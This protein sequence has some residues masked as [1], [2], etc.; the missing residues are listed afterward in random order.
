MAKLTISELRTELAKRLKQVIS[1]TDT[2]TLD[3]AIQRAVR[4]IDSLASYTFL[5]KKATGTLFAYT[6]YINV[7]NDLNINKEIKLYL[8]DILM[9]FVPYTELNKYTS[10]FTNYPVAYAYV[11]DA[12]TPKFEFNS[13]AGMNL[14]YKL[15][16][17]KIMTMPAVGVYAEIPEQWYDIIIDVAEYQQ[18]MLY[19]IIMA[20]IAKQEAM[21]KLKTFV[22]EYN[23]TQGAIININDEIIRKGG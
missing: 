8:D 12:T 22:R 11:Y 14:S 13:T 16:Y 15:Y 10:I 1:S 23:A 21:E 5:Q 6:N 9:E 2:T 19:G 7:P 18:K 4:T 3:N 20:D 17:S